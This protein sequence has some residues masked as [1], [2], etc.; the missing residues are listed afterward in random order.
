MPLGR[1]HKR[2]ERRGF[3]L[4]NISC[5]HLSIN[6]AG[7]RRSKCRVGK[8]T[9][10]GIE[11]KEARA[12]TGIIFERKL[13]GDIAGYAIGRENKIHF[14]ILESSQSR[15]FIFKEAVCGAGQNLVYQMENQD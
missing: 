3:I 4:Q 12:V 8:V 6:H 9:I 7:K 10:Q 1:K 14:I 2:I 15:I 5:E 11:H 13:G